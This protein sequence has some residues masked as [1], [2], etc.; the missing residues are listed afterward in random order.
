MTLKKDDRISGIGNVKYSMRFM[1]YI[2]STS[3][4]NRAGLNDMPP[5]APLEAA[6]PA[7][8][9]GPTTAAVTPAAPAALVTAVADAIT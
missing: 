1:I 8:A 5:A 6:P 7:P 4:Q 9:D 2:V 3:I